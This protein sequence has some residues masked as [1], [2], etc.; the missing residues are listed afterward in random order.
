MKQQIIN[1]AITEFGNNSYTTASLNSISKNAGI[2]KGII[3]HYFQ[4]KDDL[5]LEC[6][7]E[8]F[9]QFVKFLNRAT[10]DRSD[11]KNAIEDYI[12]RRYQFFKNQPEFLTIFTNALF[13]P[14]LHL[15]DSIKNIKTKLDE[16][17]IDFL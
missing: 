17:N 10:I 5:Y 12:K 6:V 3:Y 11:V 1:S 16:F 14:P 15:L 9:N 2:S 8:C 13:Q 4:N 7:S